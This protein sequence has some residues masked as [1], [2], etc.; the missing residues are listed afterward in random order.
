[1]QMCLENY[2]CRT[3]IVAVPCLMVGLTKYI[4]L[5]SN[6]YKGML[7]LPG[8]S[9]SAQSQAEI[10]VLLRQKQ[11]QIFEKQTSEGR[12]QQRPL[13]QGML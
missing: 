12:S 2:L 10:S 8:C 9:A 5:V 4:Q 11:G 6:N 7:L 13:A 1:M 3:V